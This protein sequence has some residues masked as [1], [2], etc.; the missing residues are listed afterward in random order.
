MARSTTQKTRREPDQSQGSKETR[1]LL[2]I[3]EKRALEV[4]YHPS[5]SMVG[6]RFFP[7]KFDGFSRQLNF[8]GGTNVLEVGCGNGP[9]V[10]F[11]SRLQK[12]PLI[13]AS[14]LSPKT[15]LETKKRVLHEGDV[16]VV[17]FCSCD[18]QDLPF[19][20][21]MFDNVVCRQVIEH[22]LDDEK[23]LGEL[24]RV[25]KR[26]GRLVISTDNRRNYVTQFFEYPTSFLKRMLGVRRAERGYPHF[27]YDREDFLKLLERNGFSV[28]LKSIS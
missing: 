16:R 23:G 27:N 8:K 19:G 3:Y 11:L 20:D 21:S 6:C 25:M 5:Q 12:H 18:M 15:L 13:L 14:D 1:S 24:A 9:P 26:G 2:E 28:S 10:A 7:R 4:A 22:L 17:R